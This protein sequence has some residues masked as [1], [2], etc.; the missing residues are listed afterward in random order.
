MAYT[1]SDTSSGFNILS[2]SGEPL[3]GNLMVILGRYDRNEG[4]AAKETGQLGSIIRN[5]ENA[6]QPLYIDRLC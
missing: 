3:C 2:E 5:S 4:R 6:T 1:H